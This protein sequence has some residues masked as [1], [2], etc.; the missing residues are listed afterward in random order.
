MCNNHAFIDLY[1][2][3]HISVNVSFH[4]DG[5]P[6]LPKSK[7]PNSSNSWSKKSNGKIC[8]VTYCRWNVCVHENEGTCMHLKMLSE[9]SC[10]TAT[11][12][13]ESISSRCLLA[14][15]FKSSTKRDS[16]I[17]SLCFCFYFNLEIFSKN[18]P[19]SKFN[20]SFFYDIHVKILL[21][22]LCSVSSDQA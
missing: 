20:W 8:L 14:L 5:H 10:C 3:I 17:V 2:L 7:S 4:R 15:C 16:A 21:F 13:T 9:C 1:M 11:L 22:F 6:V 12:C 18:K 19:R